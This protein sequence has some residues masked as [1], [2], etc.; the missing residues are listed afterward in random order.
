MHDV[1]IKGIQSNIRSTFIEDL[2]V[3]MGFGQKIC[4]HALSIILN[5][6]K[7]DETNFTNVIIL[8]EN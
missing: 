5:R 7:N 8:C 6:F 3:C 2:S 4:P 1:D